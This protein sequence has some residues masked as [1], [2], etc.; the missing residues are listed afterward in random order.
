M[1]AVTCRVADWRRDCSPGGLSSGA[2][3]RGLQ[4]ATRGAAPQGLQSGS[5]QMWMGALS[6]LRVDEC[7]VTAFRQSG[8]PVRG[9]RVVGSA[10]RVTGRGSGNRLVPVE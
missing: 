4:L 3:A 8:G 10:R 5:Q 2:E 9:P 6:T 1:I 7:E